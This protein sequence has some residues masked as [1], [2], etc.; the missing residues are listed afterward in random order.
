MAYSEE[1]PLEN[2]YA[3][4]RM[5]NGALMVRKVRGSIA[6]TFHSKISDK[7]VESTFHIVAGYFDKSCWAEMQHNF[8]CVL[9]ID[10]DS[11]RKETEPEWL[12]R[13]VREALNEWIV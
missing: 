11:R 1:T 4:F 13:E 5:D 2:H 3:V 7:T 8:L 9:K 10:P 12:Q 6:H